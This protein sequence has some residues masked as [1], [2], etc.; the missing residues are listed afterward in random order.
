MIKQDHAT[1]RVEDVM[2]FLNEVQ[3]NY[4]DAIS[5]ASGRPDERFFDLH[6]IQEY[7]DAFVNHMSREKNSTPERILKDL[8]QYNRTKGVINTLIAKYL[9]NDYQIK[10]DA[11]DILINVGSQESFILTLLTLCNKKND[12]LIVED[13]SYVGI[14]HFSIIAQYQVQPSPVKP[15]GLCLEKLEQNILRCN[16]EQK[17]V[18]LVYVT[19]DFQNPTGTRM[20]LENRK[21]LLQLAKQYNFYIIEDNA[22]GDFVFEGEKL[23]T[24]KS[25]DK[26]GHVIYLHSFSKTIYP[27]LRIGAMVCGKKLEGGFKLSDLMAKTKGYT[28]VN[29]P[30]I[31]QM[32]VGGMLIENEFS[33]KN[34]NVK[35]I[36]K[37]KTKRNGILKALHKYFGVNETSGLA[38]VTWNIPE[39]GYFL[40]LTLP[41]IITKEDVIDCAKKYGV[42][43][44][45]MSFFHLSNEGKNQIRIAYSYVD[46]NLIETAIERLSKFLY[47][48]INQ[49]STNA[50]LLGKSI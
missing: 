45:P 4:P 37:L 9:E 33:F 20:P 26:N 42:I 39:G 17:H 32:I 41:I 34:Y 38:Q 46:E 27:A 50:T 23:P 12:V 18:K 16:S 25:L 49:T 24:I 6:K 8:G 40:T 10:A 44:T 35:K 11:D 31:T 3:L 48:K 5:L 1:A 43:T 14:S 21:K 15:T 7:I 28:T 19:P 13:P 36:E 29:T 22:Y 2:G 30:S 47:Q